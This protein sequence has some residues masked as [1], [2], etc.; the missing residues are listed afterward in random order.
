MN[1]MEVAEIM[2]SMPSTRWLELMVGGIMMV[3]FCLT[4]ATW[5]MES[6]MCSK[7]TPTHGTDIMAYKGS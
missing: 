4:P 5:Q 6:Y 7:Y 1:D 3:G 2:A